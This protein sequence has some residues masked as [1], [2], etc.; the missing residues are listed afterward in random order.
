[1]KS[2]PSRTASLD[3]SEEQISNKIIGSS[4]S[5]A[6]EQNKVW[7][8]FKEKARHFL[9]LEREN[10]KQLIQKETVEKA[11]I[12]INKISRLFPSATDKEVF[13]EPDDDGTILMFI[14]FDQVSIMIN[15]FPNRI[16]YSIKSEENTENLM[17]EI[18]YDASIQL[19]EEVENG[20]TR[21]WLQTNH[22]GFKIRN[23]Y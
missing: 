22:H 14:E 5:H 7:K 6:V 13:F 8:R 16:Q 17:R 2:H 10:G 23:Q 12:V 18:P 3:S 19:I 15:F 11:T 1:M 21:K 20:F 9:I 4:L